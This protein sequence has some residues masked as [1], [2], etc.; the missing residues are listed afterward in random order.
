MDI[1][2]TGDTPQTKALWLL[3]T[4][5]N[6]GTEVLH[7]PGGAA[8]ELAEPWGAYDTVMQSATNTATRLM[9]QR[10]GNAGH[11]VADDSAVS[12]DL[13]AEPRLAF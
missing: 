11:V 1:L 3:R 9:T 6:P 12:A 10:V 4:S 13:L 8:S 5:L 2:V 7:R